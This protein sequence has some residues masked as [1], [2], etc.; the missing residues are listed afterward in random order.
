MIFTSQTKHSNHATNRDSHPQNPPNIVVPCSGSRP[1]THKA[2]TN[3]PN[4]GSGLARKQNPD[5]KSTKQCANTLRVPDRSNRL[6][7][8]NLPRRP[9]VRSSHRP[10]EPRNPSNR[11]PS[12]RACPVGRAAP[13][14]IKTTPTTPRRPLSFVPPTKSPAAGGAETRRGQPIQ[15]RIRMPTRPLRVAS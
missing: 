1:V 10:A 7:P 4:F 6:L 14:P 11:G 15:P 13:A 12:R 8:I 5:P 9:Q 3:L 2:P